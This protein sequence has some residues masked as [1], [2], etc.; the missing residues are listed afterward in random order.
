MYSQ[1]TYILEN[2]LHWWP[3]HMGKLRTMVRW[4][5]A[6]PHFTSGLVL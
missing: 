5:S 6:W 4:R 3:W 2:K 1:Q